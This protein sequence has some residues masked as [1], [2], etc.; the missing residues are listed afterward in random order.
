[1]KWSFPIIIVFSLIASSCTPEGSFYR[2]S[3]RNGW[4]YNKNERDR[5]VRTAER[6]LGVRYKRG[7]ATPR[8]FDCSGYVMYVYQR[9]G[10]LLPRSVVRQY[11]A[12]K[13]IGLERVKPGDL[14]FFRT[15]RKRRLSHVGIYCGDDRFIHAPRSGKK[16]SF[17]DMDKAY[18]RK[19][20][21][22]AVTFMSGNRM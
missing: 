19:R 12:G 18:W 10:I 8:G 14:L 6:Y 9:N 4:F 21:I 13:K 5:I 16:V 2:D 22:G 15:S 3:W 7:G 17:A 20:Y 1:M 11:K